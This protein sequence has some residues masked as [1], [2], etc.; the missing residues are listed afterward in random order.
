VPVRHCPQRE[1]DKKKASG[2]QS[3]NLTVSHL[4]DLGTHEVGRVYV[5]MNGTPGSCNVL[6]DSAATSHMFCNWKVF[7]NYVASHGGETV[8]VGDKCTLV[9]EGQGSVTLKIQLSNGF[10]T[11]VLHGALHVPWLATNLVSLG[12]LQ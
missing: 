5:T 2:T 3:A 6:L 9:V 11:I 12:A 8:S 10:W 4:C 1:E 7:S